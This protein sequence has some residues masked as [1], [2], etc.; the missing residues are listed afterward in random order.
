MIIF[1][2]G[3][4]GVGKSTLR[5][6]YCKTKKIIPVAA[7]T[8]R[9]NRC[10]EIE[11]HRTISEPDFDEKNKNGELCLIGLNHGFKYGYSKS[12]IKERKDDLILFE[13]DSK[14]AIEEQNDLEAKIVRVIPCNVDIAEKEIIN[15]RD[16]TIDRIED[17]HKQLSSSFLDHRKSKGD[18]FY[19]NNYDTE[20]LINFIHFID[21][22][23]ISKK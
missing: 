7:Y 14:T 3:P 19:V 10:G 6:Y 9:E 11:I 21:N 17:L 12:E 20:S 2:T 5:D 23:V 18:I 1:I 15:K 13:V 4:S 22:D 8:T 16:D